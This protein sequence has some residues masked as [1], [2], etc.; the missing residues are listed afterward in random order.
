MKKVDEVC[1]KCDWVT[2]FGPKE[3]VHMISKIIED[4]PDIIVK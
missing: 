2:D 3:I 1:E 4:N